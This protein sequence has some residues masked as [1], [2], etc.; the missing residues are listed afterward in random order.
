MRYA[1]PDSRDTMARLRN[2]DSLSSRL[3][4]RSNTCGGG[5]SIDSNAT[6]APPPPVEANALAAAP[7]LAHPPRLLPSPPSNAS[8]STAR[9]ARGAAK[10]ASR[11]EIGIGSTSL[12]GRALPLIHVKV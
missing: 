7:P 8:S 12:L 9:Q 1:A 6:V 11:L 3:T 2:F 4:M 10:P 5:P